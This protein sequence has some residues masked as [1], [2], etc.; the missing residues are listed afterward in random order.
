MRTMFAFFQFS[1]KEEKK[2]PATVKEARAR[3]ERLFFKPP[4]EAPTWKSITE[5]QAFVLSAK[6]EHLRNLRLK[7]EAVRG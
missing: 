6:K 2:R 4:P 1:S 5:Q 3:A 7:A